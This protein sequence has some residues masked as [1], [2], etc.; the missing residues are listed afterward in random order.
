[1][2]HLKDIYATLDRFDQYSRQKT[3]RFD[4]GLTPEERAAAQDDGSTILGIN[5][6]D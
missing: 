4:D 3:S 2:Q 5:K 6:G 1:M